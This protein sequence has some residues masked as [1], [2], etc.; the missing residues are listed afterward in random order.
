MNK[1]LQIGQR[2]RLSATCRRPMT[3]F[4]PINCD[5]I[6]IGNITAKTDK[7]WVQWGNHFQSWYEP[8]NSDLIPV[9]ATA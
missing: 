4:D 7:V 6:V 8:T 3:H 9:E 1:D 2:V 5:G